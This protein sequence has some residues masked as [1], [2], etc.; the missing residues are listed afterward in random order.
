M[1]KIE[2]F[3]GNVAVSIE[4]L[5]DDL[6]IARLNI[7]DDAPRNCP[8]CEADIE[9]YTTGEVRINLTKHDLQKLAAQI[10]AILLKRTNNL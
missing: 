2:I 10:S 4:P 6:Y 1:N 5:E 8:R 7:F 9:N 3:L